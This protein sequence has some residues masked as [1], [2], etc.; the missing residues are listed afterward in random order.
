MTLKQI[1][2]NRTGEPDKYLWGN[3]Y[4]VGFLFKIFGFYFLTYWK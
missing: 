3:D 4:R 1:K 2:V